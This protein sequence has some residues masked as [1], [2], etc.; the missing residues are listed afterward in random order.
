M[1]IAWNPDLT[2][3]I[4]QQSRVT[5]IALSLGL[6]LGFSVGQ[7]LHSQAE[8]TRHES[9]TQSET[10]E[11]GASVK[12]HSGKSSS[13]QKLSDLDATINKLRSSASRLSLP[14]SMFE[15]WWKTMQHDPDASWMLK[16]FDV[17]ASDLDRSWAFPVGLGAY[18]PRLDTSEQGNEIKITAEVPGIDESNL[19][20]TVND[21]SVTIKG[22]KQDEL[23]HSKDDKS[24]QTIERAYGSFERTVRLP[25]KVQSDK[26]QALLKNGVLTITVPKSQEPDSQGKKL[27]IRRS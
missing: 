9:K 19:D 6:A 4:R 21:D 27:T 14:S 10:S 5:F 24:I 12:V 1:K 26:A 13:L 16:N 18:I 25:C 20:V 15:P 7:I 8:E 3:K 11:M 23:S 22:D 17:M 2:R